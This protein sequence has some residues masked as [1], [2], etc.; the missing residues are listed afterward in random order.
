MLAGLGHQPVIARREGWV[1]APGVIGRKEQ[2][3]AQDGV[4]ALRRAAVPTGLP[5]RVEGGDETGEGP[6]GGE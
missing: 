6:L 3:L 5:G 4:T 2:G 1:E